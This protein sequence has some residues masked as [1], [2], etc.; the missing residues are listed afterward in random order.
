MKLALTIDKS[1]LLASIAVAVAICA[2]FLLKIGIERLIG[3]NSATVTNKHPRKTGVM[4]TITSLLLLAGSI[5]TILES[6]NIVQFLLKEI[7]QYKKSIGNIKTASQYETN[8]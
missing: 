2:S 1:S 7:K 8:S 3:G 6:D 5:L 4:L